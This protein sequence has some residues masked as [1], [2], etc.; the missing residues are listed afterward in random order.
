VKPTVGVIDFATQTTKG[1]RNT[2]TFFDPKARQRRRP[3]RHFGTDKLLE[4]YDKNKAEGNEIL[5][6]LDNSKHRSETYLYHKILLS[7]S[8]KEKKQRKRLLLVTNEHLFYRTPNNYK[9]KWKLTISDITNLEVKPEGIVFHTS[10]GIQIAEISEK[11]QQADVFL[12]VA[13][14]INDMTEKRIEDTR[15][16]LD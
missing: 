7:K 6:L 10:E 4:P 13:S 8:P 12:K 14:L 15:L 11:D 9:P 3:P 2:A 16:S 1:I 5:V